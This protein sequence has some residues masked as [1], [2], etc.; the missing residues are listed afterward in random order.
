MICSC[1][2][3]ALADPIFVRR[4][5][6]NAENRESCCSQHLSG[7]PECISI[8][9][10]FN[11]T[12]YAL[13][14]GLCCFRWLRKALSDFQTLSCNSYAVRNGLDAIRE[15]SCSSLMFSSFAKGEST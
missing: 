15:K 7:A 5:F 13:I 11:R 10:V 2:D 8:A 12:A 4:L 3:R 9:E 14:D 1:R 6:L